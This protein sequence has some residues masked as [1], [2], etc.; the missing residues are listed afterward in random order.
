M[1]LSE[2]IA[3]LDAAAGSRS[4]DELAREIAGYSIDSRATGEG[5]LFFAIRGERYDGHEFAADALGKGAIAAVVSKDF[6]ASARAKN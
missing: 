6:A 3:I 1:K 2:V 4:R 5:E